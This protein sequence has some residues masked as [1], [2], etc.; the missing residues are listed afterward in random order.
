MIDRTEKKHRRRRR[1]WRV[2]RVY[3]FLFEL[4]HDSKQLWSSYFGDRLF[5]RD[6]LY[7]SSVL[8]KKR[9]YT[10]LTLS[11]LY[12]DRANW[13]KRNTENRVF[14]FRC[15]TESCQIR[16]LPERWVWKDHWYCEI[17]PDQSS[18]FFRSYRIRTSSDLE[19]SDSPVRTWIK[20]LKSKSK[21][22]IIADNYFP[23]LSEKSSDLVDLEIVCSFSFPFDA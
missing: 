11:E 23:P 5:K 22:R 1:E 17:R 16:A 18:I 4:F 13:K 2:E 7:K 12:S 20:N 21:C 6:I 8:S 19:Q 15:C 10:G 14:I 9:L 3:L